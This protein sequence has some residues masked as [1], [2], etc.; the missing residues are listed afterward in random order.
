MPV[1]SCAASMVV[2]FP[3][4]SVVSLGMPIQ[5]SLHW[6]QVWPWSLIPRL[7]PFWPGLKG[8]WSM[9]PKVHDKSLCNMLLKSM[10]ATKYLRDSLSLYQSKGKFYFLTWWRNKTTV[11]GALVMRQAH[12]AECLLVF[13]IITGQ[14]ACTTIVVS[15]FKPKCAACFH[16]EHPYVCSL[17]WCVTKTFW[18]WLNSCMMH[19][20]SMQFFSLAWSA[21]CQ[22]L[23][24]ALRYGNWKVAGWSSEQAELDNCNHH[25]LYRRRFREHVGLS[26]ASPGNGGS[27]RLVWPSLELGNPS[28]RHGRQRRVKESE[29]S[30]WGTLHVLCGGTDQ[31][32]WRLFPIFHCDTEMRAQ[33]PAGRPSLSAPARVA[34]QSWYWHKCAPRLNNLCSQRLTHST[35]DPFGRSKRQ[36]PTL[37]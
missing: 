20:V 21:S 10:Q 19:L 8:T 33:Q 5:A 6:G 9:G 26:L 23:E 2:P 31:G 32:E 37:P 25:Y 15:L 12:H 24:S 35:L 4:S 22:H 34:A 7:C 18:A 17:L 14:A 3:W 1:G 16:R 36:L 30:W 28:L 29:G 27:R 11:L 13:L